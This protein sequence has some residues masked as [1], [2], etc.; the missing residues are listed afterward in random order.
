MKKK[1]NC[2]KCKVPLNLG[3]A[4]RNKLAGLPDFPGDTVVTVSRTGPPEMIEVLKCPECGYSI[5]KT[6][7]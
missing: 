3:F 5:G 2:K 1:L 6:D 7:F 4:L